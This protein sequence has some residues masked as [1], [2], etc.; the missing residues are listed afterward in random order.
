MY[1]IIQRKTYLIHIT[2]H[3]YLSNY[4][5]EYNEYLRSYSLCYSVELLKK[6]LTVEIETHFV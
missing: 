4:H 5:I 3:I 6:Q 2:I 1:N